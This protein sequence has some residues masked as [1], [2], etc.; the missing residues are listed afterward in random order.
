VLSHEELRRLAQIQRGLERDDPAFVRR[1]QRLRHPR[2][3]RPWA[4][5]PLVLGLAG[6]LGGLVLADVAVLV[7]LGVVPLVAAAALLRSRA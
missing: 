4:V 5:A 7:V 1:L 6:L 2:D 3:L